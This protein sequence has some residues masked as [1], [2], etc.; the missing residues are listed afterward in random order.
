MAR[1]EAGLKNSSIAFATYVAQTAIVFG[2]Y[3]VAGRLGQATTNIRS[4]NLGPVWPAFG[5]AV[6]AVLLWGRRVWPAI[7]AASFLVAWLS[8]VSAITAAGQA[9][10]STLGALTSGFLLVRVAK[11]QNSLSRLRDAVGMILLGAF[12]GATVSATIGIIV[13]Y[14]TNSA[15][16]SGLGRAWLIYWMGDSTGVL[17]VTPLLLTLPSLF[18]L[19]KWSRIAELTTLLLLLTA[20]CFIIFGDQPF[21]PFRLHV[22][23]FAVLPFVMWASIRF[24]MGGATLSTLLIATIATVATAFGFGPFAQHDSFVNAVLLDLFFVL[25]TLSGMTLAAVIAEREHLEREREQ[26]I[27]RQSTLD[28]KLRL[29]AIVESSD[30][31]IIGHDVNASITD[32]NNGAQRLYG[33]SPDEAI[34]RP[35]SFLTPPEYARDFEEIIGL[36][37][38]GSPVQHYETVHQRKDGTRLEVSVT[39]SMIRDTNGQ[40]VG[41]AT[42]NRDISERKRIDADIRDSEARFRLVADTAPVL[43]WMSGTDTMCTYFNKPWLNFVGKT[44]ESQ[45]GSG[46]VQGV[47]PEDVERCVEMYL[48]SFDRRESFQMEYRLQRYDG[49]Y[50]W[51]FDIGVPRFDQCQTFAGYIGSAIDVTERKQA[52]E[53]LSG[54]SRRLIEAQDRERSRIARELHDDIGQR[55]SLVVVELER[56]A[57]GPSETVT[58]VRGDVVEIGEQVSQIV[59]DVQSLSR[60]LH[61][62]KLE[63]LGMVATMRSFCREFAQQQNL[64]IEFAAQDLPQ[65]FPQD[66][67]LGLFR[68]LQE[69]LHNSAKHSGVRRIEVRLWGSLSELHLMVQ[70]SGLGFDIGS[71]KQSGG[72]GLISMDERLKLL[73]GTLSIESQGGRGTTVHARIPWRWEESMRVAG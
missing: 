25:L 19:R 4:G 20:T 60:E 64:E 32:W 9:A 2:A 12:G 17:L 40:M 67:S 46:W 3:F 31:A 54:L 7:F 14:T 72:L 62:S 11:F 49:E 27:R 28:L 59:T 21:L 30:D 52:E 37:K 57:Q 45:I 55:L 38:N 41:A 6:A 65:R 33:Y 23:A 5:F 68:V 1:R 43:I 18:W 51:I 66:V 15:A 24:G 36:L 50:R 70:D 35:V 44:H 47:H 63:Y 61:S 39:A 42:I 8:P 34:G 73:N 26:L 58:N 29:A 16:Y 48:G 69:S 13:L 56:L 10:G 71:A 22:M 53:A